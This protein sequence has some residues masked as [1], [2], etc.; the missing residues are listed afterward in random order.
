M[1]RRFPRGVV[2]TFMV[3]R[4]EVSL[5]Q[6]PHQ[7]RAVLSVET[8]FH[9][10]CRC[11]HSI[12]SDIVHSEQTAF[13]WLERCIGLCRLLNETVHYNTFVGVV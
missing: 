1:T 11:N 2:V 6:K 7:D 9:M 8:C 10:V 3:Y 5:F 12:Y 13:P 4:Y